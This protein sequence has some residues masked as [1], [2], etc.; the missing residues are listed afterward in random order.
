VL[1]VHG[2]RAPREVFEVDAVA[3]SAETYFDAVMNQALALH[4][5]ADAHPGEQIDGARFQ[6]AG[7]DALLA[8]LARPVFENEGLNTVEMKQVR[9]DEACRPGSDDS[10][11]RAYRAHSLNPG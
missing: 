2:N 4:S 7:A 3:L 1:A 9:K 11:L 8:I 10:D 6:N 5:I